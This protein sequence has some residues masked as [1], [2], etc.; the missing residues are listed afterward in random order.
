VTAAEGTALRCPACGVVVTRVGSTADRETLGAL[1]QHAKDCRPLRV[2]R[3]LAALRPSPVRVAQRTGYRPGQVLQVDWA[4]MPT[5][6]RI[7][8]RE[9]RVYALICALPYSGVA[10][11]VDDQQLGAVPEAHG[12]GP[13]ALDGG[14]SGASDQLGGGGVRG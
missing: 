3:R 7:A 12:V 5:R 2:K 11:L 14:L 13:A 9:R 1:D 10:E 4:E 6:P 8:G